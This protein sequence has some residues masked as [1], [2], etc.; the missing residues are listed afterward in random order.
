MADALEELRLAQL[1]FESTKGTLVAATRQLVG[2]WDF[3]EPMGVYRSPYAQGV[4]ANVGGAG[5]IT[6]KASMFEMKATE[7]TA[8][9]MAAILC[10]GV[11]NVAGVDS[12]GDVTWT[13]SPQLTTG[14]PTL[15]TGTLEIIESDGSTNHFA[16]KTGYVLVESFKIDWAFNEIAKLSYKMF[17]RASQTLT[18]A[19]G[20]TPYSTRL[21]LDSAL[22]SAYL[23]TSWSGLGGTLVDGTLRSA[24]LEV[25][26]GL[27]PDTKIN[28]RTDR[29]FTKEKVGKLTAKLKM[30]YELDAIGAARIAAYRTNDLAWIRLK[31]LGDVI[32]VAQRKVQIDG[33]YRFTSEPQVSSDGS[34]RLVAIDM[35]SVY[36]P[37]GGKSLE[38]VLINGV[39][40]L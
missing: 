11:R 1:G 36:D 14:I 2:D 30:L 39:A 20:L 8:E 3:R 32:V 10:M 4:R 35:E 34:Q 23:D 5:Q 15:K 26:T 18:P 27:A 19:T 13:F 40:T 37:T 12:S 21:P 17:G 25:N 22:M 38:F 6:S 33:A 7:L 16:R 29:D 24:S 28:G 9:E 31:Q